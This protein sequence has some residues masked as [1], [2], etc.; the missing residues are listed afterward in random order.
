MRKEHK[1]NRKGKPFKQ[2]SKNVIS[3]LLGSGF[4]VPA[5]LPKVSDI[6][7]RLS[8]ISKDEIFIN[9]D[10]RTW[11]VLQ[12]ND[13]NKEMNEGERLFVQKFLEFYNKEIL[14]DESCDSFHYEDFYDFYSNY[15]HCGEQS[16]N[17]EK[18]ETFFNKFINEHKELLFEKE[19]DCYN[20][21]SDFNGTFNQL[22]ASL[23]NK[24]K[25]LKE[26]IITDYPPYNDFIKFIIELLKKNTLKVH[27]LN[28]D[29]F[30]DYI[31]NNHYKLSKR[32][33]DG[34]SLKKSNIYLKVDTENGEQQDIQLEQFVDK[35]DRPLCLFKLHGSISNKLLSDTNCMIKVK[36]IHAM[37]Q[38]YKKEQNISKVL[39]D[40]IDPDF[41]SGTTNKTIHY[42]KNLFYKNQLKHFEQNLSKSKMLIIIGYGFRDERINEYLEKYFLAKG[43][44]IVIIDPVKPQFELFNKCKCHFIEKGI[45]NVD[46]KQYTEILSMLNE[47]KSKQQSKQRKNIIPIPRKFGKGIITK[48]R[49][50]KR[51][52]RKIKKYL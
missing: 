9:T 3:F 6:N 16:K 52:R 30:F 27:T 31:G 40:I 18:I 26:E 2:S 29:L 50:R 19:R 43:K 37:S 25:Y 38:F 33:A 28:H 12:N 39:V 15:L 51:N 42:T 36:D 23:L 4:S 44:T 45:N 17:A 21:I 22:L 47:L 41:L 10:L 24:E 14:N 7:K 20:R 48:R 35:Y 34:F 8:K 46:T 13:P 1:K 11:F 32:F 49:V 5:G